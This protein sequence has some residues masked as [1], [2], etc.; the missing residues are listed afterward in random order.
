VFAPTYA[1]DRFGVEITTED[2]VFV[3]FEFYNN[4]AYEERANLKFCITINNADITYEDY[5]T[6]LV[7]GIGSF[8]ALQSPSGDKYTLAV[9]D[10]GDIV[11]K[12][13]NGEIAIPSIAKPKLDNPTDTILQPNIHYNFGTVEALTLTF[14]DGET[15]K[16]NEYSFSFTSGETAT[17]LTLPSS[18]QWANEITVEPNKRYEI[19]IVDNIALWCAVDLAVSE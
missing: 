3:R 12:N 10:N 1:T 4:G 13:E 15:D 17:V 5:Y 18:V 7:G 9:T 2:T 19:S 6:E 11:S 16:V 14:A 8:M